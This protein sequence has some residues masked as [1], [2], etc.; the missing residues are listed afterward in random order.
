MPTQKRPR[1]QQTRLGDYLDE[2]LAV[3]GYSVRS[4][5]RRVGVAPAN[6]SKFKRKAL[7]RERI[8]AWADALRLSGMERDR[9][10]YLAWWDH[11]PVF[12]RERLERFEDSARRS[13]RVPRT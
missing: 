9:F 5:A 11:T 7:P 12:M 8:E 6:V 2:L 13:R 4:F 10:L 1:V 3:R